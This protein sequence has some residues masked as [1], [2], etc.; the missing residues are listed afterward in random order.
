MKP[1]WVLSLKVN[2][3]II[4][5]VAA[6]PKPRVL[7]IRTN[8]KKQTK[9]EMVSRRVYYT[10]ECKGSKPNCYVCFRS[11]SDARAKSGCFCWPLGSWFLQSRLGPVS[12]LRG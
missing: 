1:D 6:G 11:S 12:G 5:P 3:V 10:G 7:W 8:R 4:I 9:A 2:L